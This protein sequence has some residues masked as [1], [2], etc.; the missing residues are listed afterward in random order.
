MANIKTDAQKRAKADQ[1]AA[2]AWQLFE[3]HGFND[4]SMAMIAE[5]AGVAKGTLFNYYET[6][7]N[8]FMTLLLTGYR[9]YFDQLTRQFAQGPR[10]TPDALTAELL[11]ETTQLI[12]QHGTLVRL[13]ALR[14]PVLEA[15]ADQAQTLAER[16]ALYATSHTLGATIAAKV[17]GLTAHTASHLFIVQ[18]AVISGLMNLAG[19]DEFNQRPLTVDF[20]DFQ[21]DLERESCQLFGSYLTQLFKEDTHATQ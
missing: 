17:P 2:A 8:I 19:L 4:I 3:H 14:G 9:T 11:R 5:R 20:P 12:R 16:R 10:L 7:E 21:V 1:I 18:S 6:K 13:N 15:R